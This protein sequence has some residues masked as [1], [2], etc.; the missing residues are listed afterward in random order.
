MSSLLDYIIPQGGVGHFV[1]NLHDGLSRRYERAYHLK[2][3]TLASEWT[4]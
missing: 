2:G 1:D 4:P 3:V